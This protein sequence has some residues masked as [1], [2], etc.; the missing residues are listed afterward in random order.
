MAMIEHY[1]KG[2]VGVG[3]TG[4]KWPKTK[5]Q[6]QECTHFKKGDEGWRMTLN[7]AGDS[8]GGKAKVWNIQ[9]M[10]MS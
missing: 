10:G 2:A 3:A 8:F 7:I 9:I 6:T 5:K 1:R 4:K